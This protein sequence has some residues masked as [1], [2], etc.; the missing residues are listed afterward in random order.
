V[1]IRRLVE[2]E[3]RLAD[4][5]ARI[6]PEL[7]GRFPIHLITGEKPATGGLTTGVDAS[8]ATPGPTET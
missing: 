1:R 4:V 5:M 7:G 6:P 2:L 8:R 3:T